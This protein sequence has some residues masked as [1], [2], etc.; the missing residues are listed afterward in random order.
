MPCARQGPPFVLIPKAARTV[1]VTPAAPQPRWCPLLTFE[2]T[3]L[4]EYVCFPS[5][6]TRSSESKH[7]CLPAS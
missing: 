1:F 2:F 3:P 4:K 6:P 7:A 5:N